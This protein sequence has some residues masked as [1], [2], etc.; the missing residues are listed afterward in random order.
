LQQTEAGLLTDD[1]EAPTWSIFSAADGRWLIEQE[2]VPR[3]LTDGEALG[4]GARIY[5]PVGDTT[6]PATTIGHTQAGSAQM[7][8][9]FQ[10]SQ[11]EEYV[12]VAIEHG[13]RRR[14]LNPRAFH[15]LLLILARERLRDI[16]AGQP[17]AEQG[18]VHIEDLCR[19]AQTEPSRINVDVYRA[20]RQ[21]ASMGVTD[22][23]Q[24]IERR[25]TSRQ[26]R[27]GFAHCRVLPS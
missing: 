17:A 12:E 19:M 14:V 8:L 21:L 5:L 4:D 13:K 7:M 27:M 20:R 26:L 9:T 18:W 11:D 22:A 24:L 16:Q 15:Y 10:V 25:S 3:F 6:T 23:G 1:P 2:G